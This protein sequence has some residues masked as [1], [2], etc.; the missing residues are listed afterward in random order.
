MVGCYIS[1]ITGMMVGAEL[2]EHENSNFLIIDLF[3]VQFM[4]EWEKG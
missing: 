4:F 3:I 2:A 1:F